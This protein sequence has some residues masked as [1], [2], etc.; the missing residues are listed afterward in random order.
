MR[1]VNAGPVNLRQTPGFQNKLAN[2]VIATVPSGQDGSIVDGP[3]EADGLT[4]W[5]VRFGD[6]TGWMAERSSSGVT[7]LDRAP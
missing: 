2:D 4:W 3:V 6:R 7:L 1:N 5:L